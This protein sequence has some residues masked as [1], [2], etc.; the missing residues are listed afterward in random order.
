ME[1]LTFSICDKSNHPYASQFK[2]NEDSRFDIYAFQ[3]D[4]DEDSW[5]N[6]IDPSVSVV[7]TNNQISDKLAYRDDHGGFSLNLRHTPELCF[8]KLQF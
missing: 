5:V 1:A 6:F 4:E 8:T 7:P 3:G 2:C